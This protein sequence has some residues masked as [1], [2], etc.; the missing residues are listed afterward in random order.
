[1]AM[2]PYQPPTSGGTSFG[3]V[4]RGFT[5][6]EVLIALAII[7]VALLASLRVAGQG[8]FAT[9]DLRARLLAR[10]IAENRLAEHHAR[11]DWLAVRVNEGAAREGGI[12]FGWREEVTA[13]PS[14]AFRRVDVS[15]YA[16]GE[17]H[18]LVRLTGFVTNPPGAGR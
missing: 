18:A 11:A 8:A 17:T 16:A 13:T 15:V 1:G 6:I 12:D 14:L 4:R 5:L 7:A 9:G 2:L 3:R 10:W